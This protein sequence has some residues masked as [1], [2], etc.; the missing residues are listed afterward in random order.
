MPFRLR[1]KRCCFSADDRIFPGNEAGTGDRATGRAAGGQ[2]RALHQVAVNRPVLQP[3][4]GQLI[5]P[6]L[7]RVGR[8][9]GQIGGRSSAISSGEPFNNGS[10]SR[11]LILIGVGLRPLGPGVQL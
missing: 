8:T 6:R 9:P 10:K 7:R 5:I 1:D 4:R 2:V 3:G 11:Q